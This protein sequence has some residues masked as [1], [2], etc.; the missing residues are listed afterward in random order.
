[1]E[2]LDVTQE[3]AWAQRKQNEERQQLNRIIY[4][5]HQRDL[6]PEA[7]S[8]IAGAVE[9]FRVS[10]YPRIVYYDVVGPAVL[11]NSL[12]IC[13]VTNMTA[14][15][16]LHVAMARLIGVNV[17]VTSDSYLLTAAREWLPMSTP[18]GAMGRLMQMGF[19]VPA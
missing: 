13:E 11:S 19:D 12:G 1:M 2:M 8:N 18:E 3:T 10:L 17:F 5:R 14:P 15:D 6:S 9:D 4:G 16:C 7:L